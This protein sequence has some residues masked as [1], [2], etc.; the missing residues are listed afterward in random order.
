M[1]KEMNELQY[2]LILVSVNLKYSGRVETS[3]GPSYFLESVGLK[4]F[5]KM[6]RFQVSL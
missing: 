4:L 2:L 1:S 6:I 3:P 5:P